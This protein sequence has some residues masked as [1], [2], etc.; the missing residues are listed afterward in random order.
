MPTSGSSGDK[1]S[2][3][4]YV[5]LCMKMSSLIGYSTRLLLDD[6]TASVDDDFCRFIY[7]FTTSLLPVLSTCPTAPKKNSPPTPKHQTYHHHQP[8]ITRLITTY[9]HL[10]HHRPTPPPS[11]ASR[12]LFQLLRRFSSQGHSRLGLALQPCA[13]HFQVGRCRGCHGSGTHGGLTGA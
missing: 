9:H 6:P 2:Q 4:Q 13:Q 11:A 10:P 7:P 8:P 12:S 5:S 1:L 3:N